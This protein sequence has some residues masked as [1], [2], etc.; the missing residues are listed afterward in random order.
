MTTVPQTRTD[1]LA[2]RKAAAGVAHFAGYAGAVVDAVLAAAAGDALA[3]ISGNAPISWHTSSRSR[4][5]VA[6]VVM[7]AA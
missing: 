4:N 3:A 5:L 2:A 1:L 7:P 6:T